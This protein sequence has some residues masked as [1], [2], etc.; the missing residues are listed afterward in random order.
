MSGTD[1]QQLGVFSYVSV[2]DR[3]PRNHPLRGIRCIVDAALQDMDRVLGAM[4]AKTGRSSIAPEKL[5][6]ALLMQVFYSIRSE[7]QL[8][9]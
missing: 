4:Y 3:V 8:M 6:R 9:E 2:E 7:R 5:I 1:K